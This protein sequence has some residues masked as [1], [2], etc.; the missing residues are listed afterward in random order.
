MLDAMTVLV[1]ALYLLAGLLE[2]AGVLAVAFDIRDDRRRA[3]AIA[4]RLPVRA[5]TNWREFGRFHPRRQFEERDDPAGSARRDARAAAQTQQRTAIRLAQEV[6]AQRDALLEILAGS[7]ARRMWA[8]TL[9]VSGIIIGT[10][11]NVIGGCDPLPRAVTQRG[12]GA[13]PGTA[14]REHSRHV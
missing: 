4:D 14:P 3:I 7:V 9:L 6:R 12:A 11:A 2:L 5:G 10:A 8:L 1:I 13:A